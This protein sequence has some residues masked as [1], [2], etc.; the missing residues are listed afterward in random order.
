V[1]TA[2]DR[3]L[4]VGP[5][6]TPNGNL[7]LG[8]VAGPY[9][10]GDVYARYQR[11]RGRD[12]IYTTGTDDSQTFVEAT[13]RR[14]G[15]GPDELCRR[16]TAQ[17]AG[18]LGTMGIS[19]DGFGPFDDEY[20]ATVLD[21]FT[22]LH[23]AGRFR[24]RTVQLPYLER[25]GEFL[26][27]GLVEGDCPVCLA[28][29]RGGLCE[30]CGHPNDNWEL[31]QPHSTVDPVDVPT[32]R[33]ATI[34]VLPLEEYRDQLTAY[35]EAR[36]ARWRPSIV[37]LVREAMARPLPDFPI[38]YPVG[39]GIPAP[40][41][42][43]PGQ[44]LNAWAETIPA[45]MFTTAYC[46]R[47]RDPRAGPPGELW[48][49]EHGVR[50]VHFL[51]FDNAY[52]WSLP[53]VALLMAHG[54]RY[55]VPDTI[56]PN[57]FYEL[58]N[59]KLS[60]SRGHVLWCHDLLGE[61][62]RDVARFYLCITAPEHQRSSFSRSGLEKTAGKRLVG[63]WNRLAGILAAAAA[64]GPDGTLPVSAAGRARAAV[65][66]ERFDHCYELPGLSLHRA[67]DLVLVQLDRLVRSTARL[68]GARAGSCAA[69]DLFLETR[70]LLAAAA[71]ILIDVAEAAR[72]SGVDLALNGDVTGVTGVEPFALPPL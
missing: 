63:P 65:M 47:R 53:Y 60:T 68:E 52:F 17:I 11:A 58:E 7:H 69:G 18:T 54:D 3:V 50:L 31:A 36:A 37:Q 64:A 14:Q 41:A 51:G 45:A 61:V 1:V 33:E 39:W 28:Q 56:V 8:H 40:F 38:T 20:R 24:P 42:E 13:A 71:P 67:A 44:V 70:T 21:F 59:E 34:M 15:I 6:P 26:V 43:T 57:E 29:S 4:I 2:S 25:T 27:E 23:A 16:S 55:I 62:S 46:A 9:I 66:L 35:H 48:R 22:T 30:S 5:N 12:V 32:A 10:A 49:S 19:V 72:R